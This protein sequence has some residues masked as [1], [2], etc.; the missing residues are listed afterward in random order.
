[1]C[2]GKVH[3]IEVW[4]A[5]TPEKGIVGVDGWVNSLASK[6][7]YCLSA[8]HLLICMDVERT[9][10]PQRVSDLLPTTIEHFNK[11]KRNKLELV[12]YQSNLVNFTTYCNG[13]LVPKSYF[14]RAP[15]P[16]TPNIPYSG[17]NGI[18][19]GISNMVKLIQ[20]TVT[21]EG[22]LIDRLKWNSSDYVYLLPTPN[23][24]N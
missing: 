16:S 12:R 19:K 14:Q 11:V 9:R 13:N 5:L 3:V 18:T 15:Q 22:S 4:I 6:C 20:N 10:G 1:M 17:V 8:Y 2:F 24:L 21:M 23:I 7:I